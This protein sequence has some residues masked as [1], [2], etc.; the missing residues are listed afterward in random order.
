MFLTKLRTLGVILLGLALFGTPAGVLTYRALADEQKETK[1]KGPAAAAQA[2]DE[3]GELLKQRAEVARQGLK[4]AQEESQAG[5]GTIEQLVGWS[6][7]I[8]EAELDR[9]NRKAG[10]AAL[11]EH[12]E[13]AKEFEKASRARFDAGRISPQELAAA[14]YARL[15]AEI[16]LARVKA[17]Q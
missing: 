11:E 12:V 7:K 5:R 14:R 4:A 17:K 9:G 1:A 2:G 13:R 3:L 15:D 16:W 8:A 6:R 10:L